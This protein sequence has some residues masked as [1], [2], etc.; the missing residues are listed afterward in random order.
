MLTKECKES[1]IK[2]F[3]RS[4]GDTGSCEVQIALLTTR[5]KDIAQHLKSFPKDFH[6]RRGL[7]KLLARRKTYGAYLKGQDSAKYDALMVQ[8]KEL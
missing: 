3:A 6:S 1:V 4:E 7:I 2:Q 5:I 8:I